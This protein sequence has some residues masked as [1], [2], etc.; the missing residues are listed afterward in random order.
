MRYYKVNG[1][2]HRVYDDDDEMPLDL[3]VISNWR[4]GQVGEWVMAD[5]GSVIQILRRGTMLR[6]MGKNKL[7][8]YVGTCTGTF[9][10][11]DTVKM[12]TS[13]RDDIYSFSGKKAQDRMSDKKNLTSYEQKFV[14]LLASGIPAE[15]AYLQAFP[16]KNRKYAFEKSNTLIKTE[17]V[18]TAMKEE[19]K[20]VLE[21][22]GISEEYVLKTI[23]EV[24]HSTDKDETRLKALFKLA[25]IMDLED[26]N[27]TKVTQVTGALF[28]G[29]ST[30]EIETAQRPK[31][32][33]G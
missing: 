14:A 19:L 25:D 27:S 11:T 13:K 15:D 30:D 12:D 10:V 6:R 29:F 4:Y 5:D 8:E 3:L 18:R 2:E 16:T 22:L 17:R 7:K 21:E 26:K 23:K 9:P 24:I 33:D 32:I 20:P 31:E 28:Q 1:I